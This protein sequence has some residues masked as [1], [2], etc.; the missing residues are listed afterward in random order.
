M[1][2]ACDTRQSNEHT[3]VWVK[4]GHTPLNSSQ[5]GGLEW[6]RK[7]R[8]HGSSFLLFALDR[9]E[10]IET[11]LASYLA[12]KLFESVERHAS[13][14]G[15]GEEPGIRCEEMWGVGWE[16]AYSYESKISPVCS[17]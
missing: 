4:R 6:F 1:T 14:V 2:S 5:N 15:T 13:G 16:R 10:I 8:V 3:W 7:A 17:R 11:A 9:L 12:L